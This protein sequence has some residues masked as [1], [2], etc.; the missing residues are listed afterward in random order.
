MDELISLIPLFL[1]LCTRIPFDRLPN[2]IEAFRISGHCQ[3]PVLS[4]SDSQLMSRTILICI[5]LPQYLAPLVGVNDGDKC[6]RDL[7]LLHFQLHPEMMLD[8]LDKRH[9]IHQPMCVRRID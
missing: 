6:L 1:V 9:F 7:Q 3:S 2:E 4:H 5:N 8:T